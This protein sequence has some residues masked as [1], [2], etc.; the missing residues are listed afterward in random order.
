MYHQHWISKKIPS[1]EVSPCLNHTW[2]IY[3]YSCYSKTALTSIFPQSKIS[4]LKGSSVILWVCD[5]NY[6]RSFG[7][8]RTIKTW[9]WKLKLAARINSLKWSCSKGNNEKTD[10]L[11]LWLITLDICEVFGDMVKLSILYFCLFSALHRSL[12]TTAPTAWRW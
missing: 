7:R 11:L 3:G 8:W 12:N 1:A 5:S 4:S 6:L 10:I 2:N 9:E